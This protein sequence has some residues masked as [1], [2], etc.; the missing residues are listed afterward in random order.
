MKTVS[1]GVR[2]TGVRTLS[3]KDLIDLVAV[4]TG[5]KRS[6]VKI[7]VLEFVDL[8]REELGAGNRLEFRN[9]GVFEIK[10]RRRRSAQ[11]PRTLE[12]VDVPP[13][14]TVKFK[15]GA[16]L[17]EMLAALDRAEERGLRGA[18]GTLDASDVHVVATDPPKPRGRKNAGSKTPAP[19]HEGESKSAD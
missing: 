13:R 12:R 2:K 15:V 10:R 7:A 18:N 11:N 1:S 8:M 16:G 14:R 3:K 17:K 9:F 4:R 5:L 19:K 6:D